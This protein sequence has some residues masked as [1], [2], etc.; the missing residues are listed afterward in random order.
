ME[1]TESV[2]KLPNG[3]DVIVDTEDHVKRLEEQIKVANVVPPALLAAVR[4][5]HKIAGVLLR[6]REQRCASQCVLAGSM[7]KMIFFFLN[8]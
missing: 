1:F 2:T 3:M 8:C 5:V 4:S 7:R 6:R